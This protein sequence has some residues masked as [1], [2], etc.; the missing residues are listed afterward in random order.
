MWKDD[1]K[2]LYNDYKAQIDKIEIYNCSLDS[3]LDLF[4]RQDLKKVLW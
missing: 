2:E 3:N 4:P 1:F